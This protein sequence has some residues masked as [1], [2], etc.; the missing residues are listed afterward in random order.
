VLGIE[1]IASFYDFKKKDALKE[2][3]VIEGRNRLKN[4]P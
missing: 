1:L 2:H 3:L 4:Y